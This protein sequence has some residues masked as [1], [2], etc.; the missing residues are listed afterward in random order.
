MNNHTLYQQGCDSNNG[1][2]SIQN[3]FMNSHTISQCDGSSTF[4]QMDRDVEKGDVSSLYVSMNSHNVY[5]LN[6]L[7]SSMNF[8]YSYDMGNNDNLQNIDVGT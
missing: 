4:K 8:N 3:W 2:M 6:V 5:K 7:K 1:A